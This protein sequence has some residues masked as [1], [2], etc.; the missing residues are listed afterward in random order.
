MSD[1]KL[2]SANFGSDVSH[3]LDHYLERGGYEQARRALT[4][5]EPAAIIEEVKQAKLRGCGG[6]G[7]PTGVKWGFIPKDS[8]K[9]VYLAVNADEGEPGTFKDKYILLHEPHMLLEGMLICARAV[10]C[11]KAYIYVRGEFDF[12]IERIQGAVDEAYERGYLGP[13][14]MGTGYAFDVVVHRGAGAYICGEETALL[15]SLEGKAGH[16]RLKP[17]F[18]ALVGLHGCPTVINNVETLSFVPHI[19]RLGAQGFLELGVESQGGTKLYCV[20]GHVERPG[21]YEASP[22]VTL[23]ALIEEYAGGVRGG[24]KLKAVIPGGLSAPVLTPDELD[25][26]ASFDG[27]KQVGSMLGSA[28]LIVMDESVC[29]VDAMR[30]IIQFYAHES[31]GQCSPCREGTGW[32]RR[33]VERIVA[34]HGRPEDPD[35]LYAIAAKIDGTTICPLGDAAAW[36]VMAIVKKFREE[37]DYYC[38]TGRSMVTGE[39]VAG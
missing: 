34:G 33:I 13:D 18:P 14:V 21:I 28:G 30:T 20:S 36:P 38:R 29:M 17:P 15:E 7:F 27:L 32:L 10:G 11:H 35:N 12:P 4:E 16:P 1:P 9:P 31:C 24:A 6:A 3:H 2:L 22:K 19:L 25:V 23:R 26:E 8:E 37:F 39:K 5:L